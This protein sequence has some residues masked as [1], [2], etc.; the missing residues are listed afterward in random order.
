MKHSRRAPWRGSS[1][2][3]FTTA[4]AVIVAGAG[5]AGGVAATGHAAQQRATGFTVSKVGTVTVRNLPAATAQ[6]SPQP[7]PFLKFNP[8]AYAAAK[9]SPIG[10]VEPEVRTAAKPTLTVGTKLAS[11][12]SSNDDP[13]F[14]PPDMGFAAGGGFKMEQ[15]NTTGRTWNAADTPGLA[16]DLS[17]F[18]L[19]GAD[20]I[21]DPWVLFDSASGR[22]FAAIFDITLSSERLAVSATSDPT[23]LFHIYNV[24]E[25]PPGGCPDQGKVGVSDNVVAISANEFSS[26][27]V[28]PV[29]Q[30]VLITVLNKAELVAGAATVDA[31]AA[32]P[33]AGYSSSVVPA[34]S[35]SSTT[36]QWYA[37]V[38]DS[39]STVAHVVKTV[40]TPPGAV[41]LSEPFTPSIRALNTPPGADQP[42]TSTKLETNDNRVQTVAWRSGALVFTNTDACTPRRDTVV[43]S[44]SRLLSIDSATG[45][46]KIDK[47]LAKRNQHT[48]FPAASINANGTIVVGYGRSSS[49]IFPEL[50]VRASSPTGALSMANTVQTGNA[51]NETGRYGDYFALAVDP[52]APANVWVAGEVGGH[53]QFGS[54]GWGTAVARIVVTP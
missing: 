6:G 35:L 14:T 27:F 36:T 19:T 34:Q 46:V 47:D 5:S 39:H 16:F 38:D 44:C 4:V 20:L 15:I 31:A 23:G 28:S 3:A 8:A 37:G 54:G 13:R 12:L 49:S 43:R 21:S 41:T 17:T 26:C 18:Y 29:F 51:A 53:N 2:V 1:L 7:L 24:S 11:P 10:A 22:W 42:G 45:T 32:G 48:F 40:G 33:L 52:L 50:D 9:V 25:G 30:G